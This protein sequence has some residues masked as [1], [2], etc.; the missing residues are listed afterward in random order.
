[1]TI[2]VGDLVKMHDSRRRNAQYA[3]R[4][5]LC[6][7]FRHQTDEHWPELLIDGKKREFHLTQIERVIQ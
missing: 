3:G 4:I 7:G 6:V 1:M 5:A 2:N